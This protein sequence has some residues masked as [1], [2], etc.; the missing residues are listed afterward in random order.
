MMQ[1]Q[2]VFDQIVA[3]TGRLLNHIECEDIKEAKIDTPHTYFIGD[4]NQ[5]V[6]P[7]IAQAIFERMT[8]G[9]EI[10]FMINTDTECKSKLEMPF[11]S[12][13]ALRMPY[14]DQ[15]LFEDIQMF[16]GS[17]D[18]GYWLNKNIINGHNLYD[19]RATFAMFELN[20][21]TIIYF[22]KGGLDETIKDDPVAMLIKDTLFY[23]E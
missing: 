1:A 2:E 11:E 17:D 18:L 12:Q 13:I 3:I 5:E 19:Y 15:L 20:V 14:I 6:A 4:S 7:Y 10:K 16:K 21:N 8:F 22:R 23:E 9:D